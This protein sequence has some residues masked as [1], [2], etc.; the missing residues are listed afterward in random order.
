MATSSQTEELP[1]TLRLT[2]QAKQRLAERA[3]ASGTDL[4]GYVSFIVEQASQAPLSLAEISGP[5]YQRFL[6]SGMTDE[7]LGDL[8]EKEKHA[9]R[10]IDLNEGRSVAATFRE[11]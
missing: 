10:Q 5:I 4:A 3:G 1:I 8:L 11:G 6:E 2:S 9:A 7:E